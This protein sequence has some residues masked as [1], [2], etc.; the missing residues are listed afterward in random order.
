M[1]VNNDGNNDNND[2][3]T[4]H[5][6]IS[7]RAASLPRSSPDR[8]MLDVREASSLPQNRPIFQCSHV[9]L[10]TEEC[11]EICVKLSG[12]VSLQSPSWRSPVVA[13]AW[14]PESS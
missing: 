5:H 12:R 4:H 8:P 13:M 14:V 7:T 3:N 1:L 11:V 2:N 10:M 6:H 9:E